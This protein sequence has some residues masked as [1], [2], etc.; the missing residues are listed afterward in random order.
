MG[1]TLVFHTTV[2]RKKML[3]SLKN[4]VS[5]IVLATAKEKKRHHREGTRVCFV[6]ANHFCTKK[7]HLQQIAIIM[8]HIQSKLAGFFKL[9]YHKF[10]DAVC[11]N[12]KVS[13]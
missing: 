10:L 7:D 2:F 11:E 6:G 9:T 1:T 3:G 13:V 5:T 4:L 8:A 12:P